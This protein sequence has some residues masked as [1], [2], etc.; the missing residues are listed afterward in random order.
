MSKTSE[1]FVGIWYGILNHTVMSISGGIS[2]GDNVPNEC[3][4]RPL[5]SE[6]DKGWL[7][8]AIPPHDALIKIVTLENTLLSK[9]QHTSGAQQSW[10][11]S[12]TSY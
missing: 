6:C 3:Q 7:K 4:H 12:R 9:L 10:R 2:Y 5:S 1:E 11:T 8:G